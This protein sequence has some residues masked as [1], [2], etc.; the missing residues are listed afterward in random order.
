MIYFDACA[1]VKL[2]LEEKESDELR[3]VAADPDT[4]MVSSQLALTEVVRTVQRS[5]FD[6][7]RVPT[8]DP[9]VLKERM[10][11]ARMLLERV[12]LVVLSRQILESA[13]NFADD[14]HVGSLDAVH[15]VS[16]QKVG[17]DLTHF[18]TYDKRLARAA[19]A[20]GL[21]LRQP[22]LTG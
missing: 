3:T 2:V 17:P 12:N 8:L 4:I 18:I 21:P 11:S 15:L 1:L 13:A 14:P 5:G 7:H 22:G 16:A 19:E 20:A 10:T 6:D 9:A